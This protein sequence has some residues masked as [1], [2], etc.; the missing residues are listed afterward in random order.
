M[1]LKRVPQTPSRPLET[2]EQIGTFEGRVPQ[3]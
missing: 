1:S 3:R 2:L